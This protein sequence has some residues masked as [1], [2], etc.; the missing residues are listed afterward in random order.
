VGSVYFASTQIQIGAVVLDTISDRQI[1]FHTT[2]ASKILNTRSLERIGAPYSIPINNHVAVHDTRCISDHLFNQIT[3]LVNKDKEPLIIDLCILDLCTSPFFTLREPLLLAILNGIAELCKNGTCSDFTMLLPKMPGKNGAFHNALAHFAELVPN[4]P[5]TIRILTNKGS[6]II[7]SS[8]EK[9]IDISQDAEYEMLLTKTYGHYKEILN[10]R[11]IRRLGHFRSHNNQTGGFRCRH[12]SFIMHDCWNELYQC[13]NEWWVSLH[14]EIQGVLYDLSNNNLLR[15]VVVAHAA[16]LNIPAERIIDVLQVEKLTV[17][18]KNLQSCVVVL[19][20]IDT[21]ETFEV[22]SKQL[23]ECEIKILPNLFV[24]VSKHGKRLDAL[25][26][27]INGVI[28]KPPEVRIKP[29]PQCEFTCLLQMKQPK[30]L[31]KLDL[32]ICSKWYKLLDGYQSLL[33][34]SRIILEK[35]MRCYRILQGF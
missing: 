33:K 8:R 2:I 22:Y 20:A 5:Y 18:F 30:N 28:I 32:L 27:N 17:K 9:P 10:K 6:G 29:C 1:E 25:N 19:D 11:C 7:Y 34:R 21:G 13:F 14:G 3:K 24:G 4:N 16:S 26:V 12:Y 35:D 31:L 23:A 15:E